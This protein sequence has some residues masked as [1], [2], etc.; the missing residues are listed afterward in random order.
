MAALIRRSQSTQKKVAISTL[1]L[2]ASREGKGVSK[3]F[4]FE[5]GGGMAFATA[6]YRGFTR[7]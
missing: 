3:V 2:Q 4:N 5:Q 7:L 6:V 1:N